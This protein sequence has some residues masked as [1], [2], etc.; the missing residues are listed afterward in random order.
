M[1]IAETKVYQFDELGD[2][3]K[4]KAREWYREGGFDYEWW[5]AVY[6]DVKT[7]GELMGIGIEQIYF[8]GFYNQGDGA[9]FTGHYSYA[10]QAIAKVKEY[11]P[12]EY[13]LHRIAKRLQDIQKPYFYQIHAE[14]THRGHDYHK[15]CSVIDIERNNETVH[16]DVL[17]EALRDFMDWIY[18]QLKIQWDYLSSNE[19]VD[20]TIRVNEYEFT[21]DGR[22]F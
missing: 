5:D 9:C 11:A 6:E 17:S 1:R 7:I 16:L 10:K 12:E 20:D 19:E 4:E 18:R 22:R 15:Y 8:A 3:A 2:N 21:K 14:I 13:E